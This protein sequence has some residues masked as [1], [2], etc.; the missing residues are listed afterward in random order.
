MFSSEDKRRK[1]QSSEHNEGKGSAGETQVETSE[2]QLG[3]DSVLRLRTEF[4]LEI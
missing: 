4:W 3:Q 2:E 1:S